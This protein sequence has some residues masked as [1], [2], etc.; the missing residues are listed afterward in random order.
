MSRAFRNSG[1]VVD[2]GFKKDFTQLVFESLDDFLSKPIVRADLAKILAHWLGNTSPSEQTQDIT[3]EVSGKTTLT[4]WDEVAALKNLDNDQELL[5]EM[6][7]LFLIETPAKI[8]DLEEALTQGNLAALADAAHAI[9]GMAGH[10]C[11]NQLRVCS[12]TLENSA[13]RGGA[14]NFSLLLKEVTEAT[15]CLMKAL[16]QKQGISP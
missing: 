12:S 9:K 1:V 2:I 16:Q 13:R 8:L 6:I 15:V 4:C 11:A 7:D 14:T 10:F 3:S 5:G